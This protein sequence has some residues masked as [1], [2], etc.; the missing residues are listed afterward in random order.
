M[1]WMQL[2]WLLIIKYW[3]KKVRQL[4]ALF[5][6]LTGFN[7][8]SALDID[9][10]VLMDACSDEQQDARSCL[11][12]GRD[13]L[14]R[15]DFEQ[16]SVYLQKARQYQK[17]VAGLKQLESALS[18]A[19]KERAILQQLEIENINDF[20]HVNK[21]FQKV[22]FS[23]DYVLL[24]KL[25]KILVRHKIAINEKNKLY[26]AKV[27]FWKSDFDKT[28][29]ILQQINDKKSLNFL[30]LKADV[31]WSS[32][33]YD[34]AY[35]YYKL[36]YDATGSLKY[37]LKVAQLY[38]YNGQYEK[39]E[40][41]LLYLARHNSNNKE[42]QQSLGEIKQL[43]DK[44]IERLYKKY[45][46][47]HKWQD[48][49]AYVSALIEAKQSDK[50][51]S[52]LKQF[53]QQNPDNIDAIY[54]YGVRL[55]WLGQNDKA[56]KVLSQIKNK[57]NYD[58]QL[59]LGKILSWSGKLEK[60]KRKLQIVIENAGSLQ[61]VQQAKKALAYTY[62]WG[63]EKQQAKKLFEEIVQELPEDKESAE[64]LMV[65]RGN[66]QPI[67]KKYEKLLQR[68]KI[69]NEQ[70]L[71]LAQFY[72]QLKN[73][74]KAIQTY[75]K[76]LKIN[77]YNLEVYKSLGNLYL[78]KK[79]YY[80]GFGYLEYYAYKKQNT[81]SLYS[82]AQNYYWAGF[83][84]EALDVLDDLLN[85]EPGN[86]RAESLK[87]DI[88]Q[89]N[90]RFVSKNSATGG[91]R[92]VQNEKAER[93]RKIADRLYYEGFYEASLAY[94]RDYLLLNPEDYKA[95]YR[96]A[97]ALEWTGR[98]KLAAG[99][100]FL[101]YWDK[102]DDEI[103]YHYAFNLEKSGQI[104]KAEKIYRQ[105]LQKEPKK[106]PDFLDR[107]IKS[108]EAAWESQDFEHY[109][110]FYSEAYQNKLSWRLRKERIFSQVKF[111]AISISKPYVLTE[112]DHYK[113][114]FYQEYASSN[115]RDRGYKTLTVECAQQQAEACTIVDEYW[116]KADFKPKDLSLFA[117]INKRMRLIAKARAKKKKP[118]PEKVID[119][120]NI[121]LNDGAKKHLQKESEAL[122][123]R[124]LPKT[125]LNESR[126]Y[127]NIKGYY[128]QLKQQNVLPK[129]HTLGIDSLYF[130][131]KYGSIFERS[132][133]YYQYNGWYK[134]S[135][136]IEPSSFVV[137]NNSLR[138]EGSSIYLHAQRKDYTLGLYYDQF[139]KYS[140][141]NPYLAVANMKLFQQHKLSAKLYSRNMAL[142]RW[143]P[144]P[145]AKR[146]KV[147][148][149]EIN[150]STKAGD[151]ALSLGLT[152]GSVSD[153]NRIINPSFDLTLFQLQQ[154]KLRQSYHLSG[155]Y[156]ADTFN[157]ADY[158]SPTFYDSTSFSN[159]LSYFWTRQS[160]IEAKLSAGISFS[161]SSLLYEFG[162]WYI[163]K[164]VDSDLSGKFGCFSSNSNSVNAS[165]IAYDYNQCQFNM[166]YLW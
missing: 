68:N 40:R 64:Q 63:G 118:E 14:S 130:Q 102:K 134:Y 77:P 98:N 153:G 47:S 121:V 93:Q 112:K 156:L 3:V 150:D 100:F 133:I 140:D 86:K 152:L 37:G 54:F 106:L 70:L 105:L 114:Q 79:S 23:G 71:Q 166:E 163:Y 10:S 132:G 12:L 13:S 30:S 139:Q 137:R 22:Y 123:Y 76:Y 84:D 145:V 135:F 99:E 7:A 142:Y 148:L 2:T 119:K 155:W 125:S 31:C 149:L 5:F 104:E 62:L 17:T 82:L 90:P 48:L 34:C 151:H 129:V 117:N 58:V 60:A 96:Y 50:A 147:I 19:K 144:D 8:Y 55:S 66:L 107:F 157:S 80:K 74:E 101:A 33:K 6:L 46:A 127:Q 61:Q 116:E 49:K 15:G 141:I 158:Y 24:E 128:Q 43:K 97:L 38:R 65:L 73:S 29:R 110:R 92:Q 57:D 51:F 91:M 109:L 161:D 87:A 111:I 124:V 143:Q 146:T 45:Q 44:I 39:A 69:S 18:Q 4:I 52:L 89:H 53:I 160:T 126:I 42:I 108:W 154:N 56:Y 25:Y 162:L 9:L 165:S 32:Q 72:Q 113:I 85:K 122:G 136:R 67:I 21:V 78:E 95:H 159:R 138:E 59:M 26:M 88:L 27:Y 83:N 131:D 164:K 120:N 41:L 94:F 103:D 20:E 75:E 16:V 35:K 11:I 36:L 81:D 115:H 1:H 28:S